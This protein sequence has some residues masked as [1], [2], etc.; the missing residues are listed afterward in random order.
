M[1]REE[2]EGIFVVE[3]LWYRLLEP[4]CCHIR[5]SKRPYVAGTCKDLILKQHFDLQEIPS[6]QL[7][8]KGGEKGRTQYNIFSFFFSLDKV[9][10]GKTKYG[11]FSRII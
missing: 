8:M 11:F 5:L 10:M 9:Y 4:K 1:N 2:R 3:S 7:D 6:S